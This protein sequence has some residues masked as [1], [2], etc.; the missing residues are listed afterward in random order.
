M[1]AWVFDLDGTLV[2]S[3]SFYIAA[4]GDVFRAHGLPFTDAEFR[5]GL[6]TPV[7]VLLPLFLGEPA[8]AV[9]LVEL[10]KRF[11]HD[12]AK[13]RMFEGIEETL[14]LLKSQGAAVAIWT[15]RERESAEII[16]KATGLGSLVDA[17][18]SAS[19]VS[20]S[21]PDP[22]GLRLVLERLGHDVHDAVMIGDHEHDMVAAQACGVR[23]VRA[24]WS[25]HFALHSRGRCSRAQEQFEN[26]AQMKSWV[27]RRP[28]AQRLAG[29]V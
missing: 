5:Q 21:K 24:A 19:C 15:A 17:F 18:V 4:L 12:A 25:P 29:A 26:V 9:A 11:N 6:T 1:K 13:I 8:A 28:E 20:K 22:E 27:N 2:D 14:L 16:L 3:A 7:D 23:S 10:Q